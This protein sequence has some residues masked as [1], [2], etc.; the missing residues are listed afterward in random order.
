M[1]EYP[2]VGYV[3]PAILTEMHFDVRHS[4]VDALASADGSCLPMPGRMT[5]ALGNVKV[6]CSL[7]DTGKDA[8]I[9]V[10]LEDVA[11]YVT[12]ASSANLINDAVCICDVD[13]LEV[14]VNLRDQGPQVSLPPLDPGCVK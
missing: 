9:A 8:S 1:I 4:T 2:V 13:L 11:L 3:P 6:N 12:G 5:L 10:T 14:T 7:L